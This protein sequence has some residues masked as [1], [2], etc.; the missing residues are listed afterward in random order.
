MWQPFT[1]EKKEVEVGAVQNYPVRGPS[2]LDDQPNA[3]FARLRYFA[4]RKQVHLE[5]LIERIQYLTHHNIYGQMAT[6]RILAVPDERIADEADV[7]PARFVPHPGS[8]FSYRARNNFNATGSKAPRITQ[9]PTILATRGTEIKLPPLKGT[10]PEGGPGVI[11][12]YRL[13]TDGKEEVPAAGKSATAFPGRKGQKKPALGAVVGK[14]G[15][16]VKQVRASQPGLAV[17]PMS[18]HAKL[19]PASTAGGGSGGVTDSQ[20]D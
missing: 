6:K 5:E 15:K 18:V 7:L 8:H 16:E 11:N 10:K 20:I 1:F 19:G 3:F 9:P 14:D 13:A 12:L 4:E 17:K 2:S